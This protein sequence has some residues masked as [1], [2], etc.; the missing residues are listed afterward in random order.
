MNE[1]AHES[2][3]TNSD[4]SPTRRPWHIAAAMLALIAGFY[5]LREHWGH[6]GGYWPYL[7]LLACPL[8]HLMHGHGGHG[9]D[10]HRKAHAD[11]RPP[12]TSQG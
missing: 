1:F 4:R 6:V 2:P 9:Q 3:A 7:L 12:A 5:L 10:R 8:L 11:D